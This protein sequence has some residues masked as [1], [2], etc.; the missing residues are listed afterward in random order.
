MND[1]SYFREQL[2]RAAT[3]P[4]SQNNMDAGMPRTL[5][6]D[7]LKASQKV[8]AQSDRLLALVAE[9][10]AKGFVEKGDLVLKELMTLFFMEAKTPQGRETAIRMAVG[11]V[12][13]LRK[14]FTIEVKETTTDSK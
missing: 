10:E 1:M 2:M 12:K 14:K 9:A 11:I 3:V 6:P 4:G 8:E 13:H 5:T 7:A